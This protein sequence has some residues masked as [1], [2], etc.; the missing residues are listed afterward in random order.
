MMTTLAQ[1]PCTWA[2]RALWYRSSA[3]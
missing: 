1:M 2:S 3:R